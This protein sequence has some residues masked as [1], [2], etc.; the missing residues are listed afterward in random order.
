VKEV[1]IMKPWAIISAVLVG[2]AAL[3]LF[4][5]KAPIAKKAKKVAKA[6]KE[7]KPR[8]ASRKP[9]AKSKAATKA[10]P[11]VAV[12]VAPEAKPLTKRVFSTLSKE[13][14]VYKEVPVVVA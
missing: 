9:K 3:V 8:R 13:G 10:T 12:P 4:I 11:A 5:F 1:I 6:L 7:K 14:P 2:V